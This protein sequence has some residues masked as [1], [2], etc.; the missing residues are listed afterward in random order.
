MLVQK[1]H[2]ADCTAHDPI[3]ETTNKI[4]TNKPCNIILL[5]HTKTKTKY[6]KLT[7]KLPKL[8]DIKQAFQNDARLIMMSFS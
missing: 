8:S 4:K 2:W 1:I 6:I 5:T 7:I 3:Q